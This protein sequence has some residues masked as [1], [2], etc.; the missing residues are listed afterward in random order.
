MDP[1]PHVLDAV[2]AAAVRRGVHARLQRFHE[3]VAADLEA[4]RIT[5]EE[6]EQRLEVARK[7]RSAAE[8]YKQ[9]QLL[10]A[11]GDAEYKRR[12]ML[13]D[14]ALEQKLKA[15]VD[16]NK[17]YAEAIERYQGS[18]VPSV[19]MGPAENGGAMGAQQLINLLAA[20]TAQDL[21]L[22]LG[23][24]KGAGAAKTAAR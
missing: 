18:W 16:V 3:R 13:A 1:D 4:G 5:K 19:V 15:W 8:E 22:D 24:P 11:D 2:R 21:S 7:D 6:A 9:M 23:L 20:K 14:G 12:V 10:K 17:R